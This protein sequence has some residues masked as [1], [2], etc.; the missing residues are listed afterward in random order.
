[1]TAAHVSR[2]ARKP[3]DADLVIV[4][5]LL[6]TGAVEQP[7]AE[8]LAVTNKRIAYVGTNAGARDYVGDGTIV[9]ELDGDRVVPGLIDSHLHL[10]RAGRSWV[11]EMRWSD[12][13]S[14]QDALD[15]IAEAARRP[16]VTGWLTVVG[17]WHPGQ[18]EEGRP[19]TKAELDKASPNVPVYIQQG[20]TR[21]ILNSVG[22]MRCGITA[23]R[24]DPTSGTYLRDPDTNEPTGE[25]SGVSAF[26]HCLDVILSDDHDHHVESTKVMLAD[27][28]SLGLTGAID[29]GGRARMTPAAYRA[30]Y[31]IHRA[32]GLTVRSRL[33]LHP[34][35]DDDL[36]ELE[37]I[38]RWLHPHFGDD[39][40]RVSG[41]GEI[42][43]QGCYDGAGLDSFEIDDSTK[44]TLRVAT[45]LCLDRSWPVNI[46]AIKD[47]TIRS[48]LDVWDEIDS[49]RPLAG[50]RFS[51]SHADTVT[52]DTLRRLAALGVGITVQDRLTVRSADSAQVWG[53]EAM[54][55]IP[56]LRDMLDAGVVIGGGTD[57]TVAAPYNPWTSIEWMVTGRPIDGG[58]VRSKD[59]CLTRAEAL[60][61]YTSG[62]AWFSFDDTDLGTL[63]VGKLADM[64]VLSEDYLAVPDEAISTLRSVLTLVGGEA[65]Y[66]APERRANFPFEL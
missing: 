44:E 23:D 30:L 38:T 36:G 33:Y 45:E 26:A 48:I 1:M 66:V 32:G 3:H 9:V 22:L 50:R 4:N 14:L 10:V 2:A 18:F 59:Q 39:I 65:V 43:V 7:E 6:T 37:E 46:H 42:V 60:A 5:G 62:S 17:G 47:S 58:P 63:E 20:Y 27:L 61:A 12:L 64:A 11:D 56:P 13:R 8:A 24:P 21:A 57:A 55:S 15:A 31:D 51:I 49:S 40:L 28:N 35:G 54:K 41:I 25:I 34:F 16:P 53:N 52:P 19:P 29:T